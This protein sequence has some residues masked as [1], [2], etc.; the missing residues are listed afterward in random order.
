MV[1]LV[2]L[3]NPWNSFTKNGYEK[4]QFGNM[5]R[6]DSFLYST[7]AEHLLGL[8]TELSIG[9]NYKCCKLSQQKIKYA[10]YIILCA[11]V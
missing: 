8:G 7:N 1:G 2:F 9:T 6:N 4:H 5:T 3:T 10:R 11:L